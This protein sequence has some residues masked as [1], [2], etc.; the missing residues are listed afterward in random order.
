MVF[1]RELQPHSKRLLPIFLLLSTIAACRHSQHTPLPHLDLQDTIVAFGDSL[2]FGTGAGSE[3]DSYPAVLQQLANR[4]VINA[5]VSGEVSAAGLKRLPKVLSL[6]Q[7]KLLI[8]CH[9]GND[10]LRRQ[11]AQQTAENIKQMI[12]LA[13]QSGAEVLLI[14]VPKPEIGFSLSPAEF[15][16]SV[17]DEMSVV[18]EKDSL[19]E[20]LGSREY[21]SDQIHLNAQGY[22][23]LAQRLFRILQQSGAL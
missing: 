7:P 17:A 16:G 2:T 20:L 13:R 19:S 4:K 21:K 5:G 8:I 9:G 3:N 6:Y 12:V 11:N 14:G 15:Y 23:E 10:M 18:Y 22:R 1:L